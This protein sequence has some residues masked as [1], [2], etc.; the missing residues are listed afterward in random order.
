MLS[1][2]LLPVAVL[3]LVAAASLAGCRQPPAPPAPFDHPGYWLGPREPLLGPGPGG[4][5]AP[6][7]GL[8]GAV[9]RCRDEL[10]RGQW[11]RALALAEELQQ[12]VGADP[13]VEACA[14][15]AAR[16]RCREAFREGRHDDAIEQGMTQRLIG[17]TNPELYDCME[18]AAEARCRAGI[19]SGDLDGAVEGALA[20]ASAVQSETPVQ[21][22]GEAALAR[23]ERDVAR[24]RAA[25]AVRD[26]D[27]L[28]SR[29]RYAPLEACVERARS[30]R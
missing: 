14:I 1:V 22:A 26:G 10:R 20:Y 5:P 24:G 27:A 7:A 12:M 8:E 17:R 16:E 30:G 13:A 9:E 21:C 29:L 19:A 23:C 4:E 3:V 11:D 25:A 6:Y 15:V 18:E 2:V 28:R